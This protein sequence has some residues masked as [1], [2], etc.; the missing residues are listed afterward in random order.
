MKRISFPLFPLVFEVMIWLVY[1]ALYKYSHYLQI[2]H[3]LLE[4]HPDF[5][6]PVLI[7]YAAAVTLYVIP[8]YRL[9]APA[10]LQ[11]RSYGWFV[12][13][14]LIYF[15]ILPKFVNMGINWIFM[16]LSADDLHVFFQQ[17]RQRWDL[18]LITTDCITFLSLAFV[19]YSFNVEQK[20]RLLEKEHFRLQMEA[21]KAQLNPHFLF[22]T[23]NSIYGMSL[24]DHPDTPQ[25]ILRLSEM[26]RFVLYETNEATVPVEKDIHFL[27]NYIGMEK[28]RYP[29]SQLMFSITNTST[30]QVIVPLLLIPFIENS[31]KHGAHRVDE[32]C[33]VEGSLE[34]HGDQLEFKLQND[35]LPEAYPQKIGGVGLENVRR[36][37]DLYYHGRYKLRIEA[38]KQYK[39]YLH[40]TL[41]PGTD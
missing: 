23:L 31:F 40:L 30:G 41:K 36:R 27:E 9:I 5:P 37:L 25:Y 7:V 29:D 19:R 8:F 3:L 34:I 1:V 21:L 22:N 26:M 6:Y 24:A 14:T 18:Q 17:Q 12:V 35:R 11:H 15:A 39:V 28:Q 16:E 2:S 13:V 32:Q 4:G 33:R 20:K 38:A 10:L